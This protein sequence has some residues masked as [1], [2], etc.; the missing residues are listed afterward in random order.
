MS[1]IAAPYG[2]LPHNMVGG[3]PM[4]HGMIE[5]PMTVNSSVGIFAGDLINMS[6]GTALAAVATPTTTASVD[7]PMGVC[8]GVR[9]TDGV[10][11]QEMHSQFFPANGINAGHTKVFIKIVHDPDMVFRVKADGAVTQASF[12]KNATL[13]GFSAGSTVTGRSGVKLLT[14]GIAVT[15]TLAVK[16]VGF[17]ESPGFS[18]VGDAYTD[19]LVMFNPG[20]H[21]LRNATGL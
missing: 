18:A 15:A 12:G 5:V 19:V 7:T 2:L 14:A 3:A 9:Y 13:G 10:S 11:K 17:V 20:V 1:T 4:S 21:A 8:I 6:G 16:I